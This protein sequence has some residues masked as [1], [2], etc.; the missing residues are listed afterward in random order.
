MVKVC[1]LAGGGLK[2]N[3]NFLEELKIQFS[4]ETSRGP[5]GTWRWMDRFPP[6]L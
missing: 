2:K 4:L 6:D 1:E 3:Q 5:S